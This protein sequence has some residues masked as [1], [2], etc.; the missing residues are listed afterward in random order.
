MTFIGSN[1]TS[2]TKEIKKIL[3]QK[4]GAPLKDFVEKEISNLNEDSHYKTISSSLD[5]SEKIS[6]YI[7]KLEDKLENDLKS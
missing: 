5:K 1:I 4:L 3:S 6:L 2:L 7:I